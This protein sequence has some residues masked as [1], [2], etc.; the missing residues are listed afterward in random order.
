MKHEPKFELVKEAMLGFNYY[1]DCLPVE[2]QPLMLMKLDLIKHTIAGSITRKRHPKIGQNGCQYITEL[3]H[4]IKTHKSE[5][6]KEQFSA[7]IS[8]QLIY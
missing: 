4:T 3:N 5:G 8:N 6:M 2:E 1:G 7:K